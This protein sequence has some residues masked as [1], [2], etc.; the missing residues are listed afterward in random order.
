MKCLVLL[1]VLIAVASCYKEGKVRQNIHEYR[2]RSQNLHIDE[3][4]KEVEE[5]EEEYAKLSPMPSKDDIVHLKARVRNLEHSE[6]EKGEVP[7]G[8]DVPECVNHLF[9]CDGHDDCKNGHDE[10]DETCSDEPYRVGS[11]LGGITT[12]IDCFNHLPHMTIITITANDKDEHFTPRVGIKAVLSME[13]DEHSH[14]VKSINM[15]GYFNT[16]KRLLVLVP[17][18]DLAKETVYGHAVV[19]KFNLGDNDTADCTIG[20]VASKHVCGTFRGGRH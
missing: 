19:C 1:A 6:C 5:L 8:G 14:L 20:T 16:G 2:I 15:K 3:I 17:E 10:D 7:C 13:V 9:V 12:W 4:I 11:S 18:G